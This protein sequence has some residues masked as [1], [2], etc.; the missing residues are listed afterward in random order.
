MIEKLGLTVIFCRNTKEVLQSFE[1]PEDERPFLLITD[2]LLAHGGE[3]KSSE[4]N[5]GRDTGV[6]IYK[7]LR[8]QDPRLPI[9]IH[10]IEDRTIRELQG[11]NDPFMV[12][13]YDRA[14]NSKE[15]MLEAIKKFN[16]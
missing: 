13:I 7:K 14:S 1:K 6:A 5:G 16:H 10:T 12:A 9:I 15:K 4:T 8:L 2:N 3:F 11:L